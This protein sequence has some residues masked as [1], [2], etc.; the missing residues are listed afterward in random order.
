MKPSLTQVRPGLKAGG[1]FGRDDLRVE[2]SDNL[3]VALGEDEKRRRAVIG[4]G[5]VCK[6][7]EPVFV[8]QPEEIGS[9]RDVVRSSLPMDPRDCCPVSGNGLADLQTAERIATAFG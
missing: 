7:V 1:L 5:R 4:R 6:L 9:K 2:V 8:G 3:V